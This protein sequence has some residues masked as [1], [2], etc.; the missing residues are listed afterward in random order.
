M[1]EILIG[2][3]SGIVGVLVAGVPAYFNQRNAP[4]RRVSDT[5]AIVDSTGKVITM[6]RAEVDRVDGELTETRAEIK[7][8]R[9][10]L[11]RRPGRQELLDM[12]EQLRAQLAERPTRQELMETVSELKTMVEAMQSTITELKT[13]IVGLGGIPGDTKLDN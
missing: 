12:L 6:Y 8:L 5:A 11:N 9:E 4:S 13:Q 3:I 1:N 7:T 10:E 2:V